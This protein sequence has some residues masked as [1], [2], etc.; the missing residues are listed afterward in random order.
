MQGSRAHDPRAAQSAI[1]GALSGGA[2]YAADIT[3]HPDLGRFPRQA[4]I[5]AVA[6]LEAAGAVIVLRE[7]GDQENPFPFSGLISA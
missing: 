6:S 4:V 2:L 3:Q 7:T 5:Q 1:L